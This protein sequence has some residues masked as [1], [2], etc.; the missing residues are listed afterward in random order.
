MSPRAKQHHAAINALMR[1][2]VGELSDSEVNDLL[3]ELMHDVVEIG[4]D[5]FPT[6]PTPV[7]KKK[8]PVAKPKPRDYTMAMDMSVI[9]HA[10][11]LTSGLYRN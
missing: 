8:K 1:K 11:T 7:P 2:A 5:R 6:D 4:E 9:Q 3:D 10:H